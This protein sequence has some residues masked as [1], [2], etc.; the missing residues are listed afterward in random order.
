LTRSSNSPDASATP[1][2]TVLK[3]GGSVL[4]REDDLNNAVHEIYRWIRLGRRVVAVVSAFEGTTDALLTRA[5]GITEHG[6][7]DAAA[8]L[9]ATGEFTTAS[10]LSFALTRAGVHSKV[11]GPHALDLRTR[12][13]G[14]DADPASIHHAALAGALDRFPVVVIPGFVGVGPDRDLTLLGRGGSDL[15]ALFIAAELGAHCRLIKDVDGLYERDPAL[16]GPPPRRFRTLSWSDALRLDGGI[17]QHKSVRLARARSLEFEVGAVQREDVSLVGDVPTE[18]YDGP[19]H[20]HAPLR[21]ALLGCGTVGGGVLAHLRRLDRQF[22][23]TGVVVRDT[24]RH[25]RACDPVR[26]S[27][28]TAKGIDRAEVVVEMLGGL[29]PAASV[30]EHT[31]AT[32][33]HVVTA[34][35]AIIAEQYRALNAARVGVATLSYSAAVGGGVPMIELVDRVA[36]QFGVESIEGVL[37]GTSNF[38]LESLRSHDDLTFAISE[39]QRHGFAEADPT[40]DLDGRDALE[41]LRVLARHAFGQDADHGVYTMIG[42]TGHAFEVLLQSSTPETTLRLVAWARRTP[43]GVRGGVGPVRVAPDHPL[44][45]LQGPHNRLI[46]RDVRGTSHIVDGLG[47]GRWPTSESVLADLF[48]LWRARRSGAR[49]KPHPCQEAPC[50]AI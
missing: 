21:V 37:N 27:T 17:V 4:R 3:F 35:K 32:G 33:R 2:T 40:R 28:D 5:R 15:T 20:D 38:V 45:N 23:V 7:E 44:H 36:G 49:R 46:V 26:F 47:A 22:E 13:S 11:L 1:T 48:D 31:L 39:A 43:S 25:Q 18:W 16:E 8:M 29:E 19:D 14:G 24:H 6:N 30:I 50:H 34:N 42:L 9:L 41:K 10:L 12:G